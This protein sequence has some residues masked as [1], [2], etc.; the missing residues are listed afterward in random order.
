MIGRS[1]LLCHDICV[2]RL[3]KKLNV[4]W[5]ALYIFIKWRNIGQS[6]SIYIHSIIKRNSER[7]LEQSRK[8][9]ML[10]KMMRKKNTQS[11]KCKIEWFNWSGFYFLRV[12]LHRFRER[13]CNRK[14]SYVFPFKSFLQFLAIKQSM[15]VNKQK[16]SQWS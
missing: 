15:N 7:E 10:Q 1:S 2:T 9:K 5:A 11:K 12:W 8:T 3:A 13:H 4:V 6:Y 14:Q 16:K